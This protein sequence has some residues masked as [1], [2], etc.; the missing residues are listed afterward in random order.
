MILTTF[1]IVSFLL[2]NAIFDVE[3][4][5][6]YKLIDFLK[7]IALSVLFVVLFILALITL[8]KC[9]VIQA[10]IA[11]QLF[12]IVP[13]ING[14]IVNKKLPETK[15][16]IFIGLIVAGL[17]LI[18]LSE[19]NE[20]SWIIFAILTVALA[21]V[22]G[23][24]INRFMQGYHVQMRFT[25]PYLIAAILSWL[26]LIFRGEGNVLKKMT[27]FYALFLILV[28]LLVAVAFVLESRAK[29]TGD[30]VMVS[31]LVKLSIP[32]SMLLSMAFLKEKLNSKKIIAIV[33]VLIADYLM[34]YE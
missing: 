26:I 34:I 27:V 29:I 21:I 14:V 8:D 2:G 4:L 9:T 17:V 7:V 33:I 16:L 10:V 25:L 30:P 5:G 12:Y 3:I 13:I 1:I 32:V 23:I 31:S 22:I 18:V 15:N 6:T 20:R 28:G 11:L 24:Y 19:V